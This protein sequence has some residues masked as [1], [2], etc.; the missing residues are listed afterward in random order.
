MSDDLG[1]G[2]VSWTAERWQALDTLAGDTVTQHVVLRNLVDHQE[3]AGARSA[4]IAG[5]N[6]DV[7]S[8]TADFEYDMEGEEAKR[9][10]IGRCGWRHR[11]LLTRKTRES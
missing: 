5:K 11:S 8:I 9:I 3:D 7:V 1:R 6:V 10:W 4:R 2:L